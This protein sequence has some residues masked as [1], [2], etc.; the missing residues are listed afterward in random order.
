MPFD[1]SLYPDNWEEIS[2]KVKEEQG[3]KCGICGAKHGEPHPI[4]GSTVILTTMHLD[5]NP[6]NCERSNLLAGCQRCH[7]TYDRPHRNQTAAT[8]R[9]KRKLDSG[10]LE[11]IPRAVDYL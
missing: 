6:Q 11:L 8:T 10:Q 4:T 9:H 5:H 3:W 7:N 2:L 1:R